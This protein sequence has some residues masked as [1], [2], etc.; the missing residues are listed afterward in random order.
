MNEEAIKKR[1]NANM[2]SKTTLNMAHLSQVLYS[3]MGS[4]QFTL[5]DDVTNLPGIES[6]IFIMGSSLPK[7]CARYFKK[8][9]DT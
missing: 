8:Q 6:Y 2:F 1:L 4:A 9:P 3:I 5:S 7:I